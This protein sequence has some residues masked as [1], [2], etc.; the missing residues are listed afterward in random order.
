MPIG[1]R[2]GE[3]INVLKLASS[4]TPDLFNPK[5][6]GVAQLVHTPSGMPSNKPESTPAKPERVA[7]WRIKTLCSKSNKI[8]AANKKPK[9]IPILLV[10]IQSSVARQNISKGPVILWVTSMASLLSTPTFLSIKVSFAARLYS[11][12]KAG[13][14]ENTQE[15][16]KMAA[17]KTKAIRLTVRL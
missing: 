12:N 5:A 17:I 13:Y 4:L 2:L 9:L 3:E 7:C 1:L 15:I 8:A 6:T 10:S 14:L 16:N 11:D